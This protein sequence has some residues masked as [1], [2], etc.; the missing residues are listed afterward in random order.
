MPTVL[1][2]LL[3]LALGVIGALALEQ[4]PSRTV[5]IIVPSTPGGVTDIPHDQGRWNQAGLA[6]GTNS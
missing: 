1:C 3:G 6:Q 4:Y 2:V 5:R